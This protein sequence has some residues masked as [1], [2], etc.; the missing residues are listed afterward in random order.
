MT[1]KQR[2]AGKVGVSS[3][4]KFSMNEKTILFTP[5]ASVSPTV[6]GRPLFLTLPQ[7][8]PNLFEPLPKSRYRLCLITLNKIFSH[9]RSKIS[10]CSDRS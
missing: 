8:F 5:A 2:K 9:F 7:W 1:K 4:N 10:F 6:S 3:V